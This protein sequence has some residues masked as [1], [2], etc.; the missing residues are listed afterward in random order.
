MDLVIRPV[1]A[2]DYEALVSAGKAAIPDFSATAQSLQ[3]SDVE[4]PERISQRLVAEVDGT[5]VGSMRYTELSRAHRPGRFTLYGWVDPS[6]QRKSIGTALFE[7]ALERLRGLGA[8]SLR[9]W[10]SEELPHAVRFLERRGYVETERHYTS[11]LDLT[12]FDFA[13]YEGLEERVETGSIRLLTLTEWQTY[14]NWDRRL[15]DLHTELLADVPE[16][17][18]IPPAWER[19]VE[20][21]LQ[22]PKMIPEATLI[23]VDGDRAIGTTALSR[24]DDDGWLQTRLT[25]ICREYRHRKIALA[26]K[27]KALRWARANGYSQIRTSNAGA[28]RPMLTIN[29]RLGFVKQPAG[30]TF[31][32][33]I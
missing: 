32:R 12:Q 15:F 13:P 16:P 5:P 17:D 28:N 21:E 26:L 7:A 30:I 3:E 33:E 2:G 4:Q 31:S 22:S 6:L 23:A 27:I 25:G 9:S 8:R 29:E 11:T 20:E 14:P 1:A 10:T 19:F 24:H 18:L